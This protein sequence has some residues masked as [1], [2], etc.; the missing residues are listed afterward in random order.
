MASNEV[1][2]KKI[3]SQDTLVLNDAM[4]RGFALL[5]GLTRVIISP[6]NS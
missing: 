5:Y 4:K 6:K 1:N 3:I 2:C